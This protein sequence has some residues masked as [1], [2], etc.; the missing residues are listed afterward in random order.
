MFCFVQSETTLQVI[1][2]GTSCVGV[3]VN[4]C[5]RAFIPIHGLYGYIDI[6]TITDI[7]QHKH[8]CMFLLLAIGNLNVF[9]KLVNVKKHGF[10]D[11]LYCLYLYI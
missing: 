5:T 4:V 6:L 8:S 11:D 7:R 10:R 3:R 1:R 2:Y 9:V